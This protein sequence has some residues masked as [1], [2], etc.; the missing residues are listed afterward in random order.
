MYHE[1]YGEELKLPGLSK[2]PRLKQFMLNTQGFVP[3][4]V[5]L[6][7]I[8]HAYDSSIHVDHPS[9]LLLHP[10]LYHLTSLLRLSLLAAAA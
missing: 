10:F 1:K 5:P 7:S 8:D 3:V 6:S 9:Y 4:F 2:K